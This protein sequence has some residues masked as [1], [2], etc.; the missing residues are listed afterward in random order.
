MTKNRKKKE[1]V[2]AMM[3]KASAIRVN[4]KNLWGNRQDMPR[5][6]GSGIIVSA[7]TLIYKKLGR[8]G[9]GCEPPSGACPPSCC[10]WHLFASDASDLFQRENVRKLFKRKIDTHTTIIPLNK[11]SFI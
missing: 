7:P 1:L 5:L 3:S 10:C 4:L 8:S 2:P 11:S 6:P 9:R